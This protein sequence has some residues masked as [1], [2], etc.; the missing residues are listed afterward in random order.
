MT[1]KIQYNERIIEF[2]GERNCSNCHLSTS[3]PLPQDHFE[4]SQDRYYRHCRKTVAHFGEG[5]EHRQIM[6]GPDLHARFIICP[7]SLPAPDDY[8]IPSY[9]TARHPIERR[10]Y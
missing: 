8:F 9:R 1:N 3:I 6:S 2:S 7:R 4:R 10:P 5:C